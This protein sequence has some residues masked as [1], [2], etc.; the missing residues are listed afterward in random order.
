MVALNYG[1]VESHP[2]R[3]SNIEPFISKYKWK[4]INHF[5]KVGD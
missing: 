4:R 3:V 5:S 2:E 1:E